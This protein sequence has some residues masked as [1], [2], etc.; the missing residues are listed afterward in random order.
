MVAGVVEA[1]VDAGVVVGAGVDAAG[2]V[3]A[4]GLGAVFGYSMR[5][6]ILLILY[7]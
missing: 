3:A 4:A 2:G 6:Q 1:G 7:L 5:K